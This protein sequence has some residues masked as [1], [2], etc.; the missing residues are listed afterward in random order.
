MSVRWPQLPD[1]IASDLWEGIRDGSDLVQG[2]EHAHQVYSVVGARATPEDVQSLVESVVDIARN[3]GFPEASPPDQ[4]VAFDRAA[5][6]ALLSAMNLDWNEA[7]KRGVWSFLSLVA[8]PKVTHW[9]FGVGNHERWIATDL[10]RHTWARLWWQ[11]MVF[12]GH[13]DLL[14]SLSESDLNQLLER[15][16]IGGDPRLVRAL[17]AAVIAAS[18]EIPRRAVIRD[19]T[20]RIRRR[21]AFVDIHSLDDQQLDEMCRSMTQEAVTELIRTVRTASGASER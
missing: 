17:G 13:H 19:V 8:L 4:K 14:A 7:S 5:A 9:R 10:T 20:S 16:A 12:K 6:P 3:H 18:T 2:F 1:T 15:R 21:L 11:A